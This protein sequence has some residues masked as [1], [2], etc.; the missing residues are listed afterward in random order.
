MR[1]KGIRR[2]EGASEVLGSFPSS[3]FCGQKEGQGGGGS[4]GQ[5]GRKIDWM[6]SAAQAMVRGKNFK[7]MQ[8]IKGLKPTKK[9]RTALSYAAGKM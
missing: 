1:R 3:A 6:G 8:K 2:D 9:E 7:K 5:Q 4:E